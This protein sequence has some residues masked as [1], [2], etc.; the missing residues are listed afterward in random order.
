[1][2]RLP[3]DLAFVFDAQLPRASSSVL[4]YR[5]NEGKLCHIERP[6]DDED[7]MNGDAVIAALETGRI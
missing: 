1:M 2:I 3:K 6:L 4:F 5:D 7:E